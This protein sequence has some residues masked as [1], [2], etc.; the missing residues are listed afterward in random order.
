MHEGILKFSLLEKYEWLTHGMILRLPDVD[1]RADRE[2][3]LARLNKPH[4]DILRAE[5]IQNEFYTAEQIH[6]DGVAFLTKP[7]GGGTTPGVDGLIT[8]Q[9][10][11]ALGIYVADCCVIYLVETKKRMIGLVHSGRK[12][13]EL[14]IPMRALDTML[15]QPGTA[16]EHIHAVLSPCIRACCYD[17]DFAGS[18]GD[19]IR[20]RG[21]DNIHIHPDC[22]G[23]HPDRYY[24]YRKEKGK[25]GRMLAFIMIRSD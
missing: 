12:G 2:I 10:G 4:C 16:P 14:G 17:T 19:Q 11:L 25:T 22:T 8:E 15:A 7:H 5:G 20:S 18:I 13:T 3:A 6:S 24:S 1:V 9:P 21:V 23:C